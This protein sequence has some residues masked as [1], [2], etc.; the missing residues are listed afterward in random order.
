REDLSGASPGELFDA[1]A[2][3]RTA[4]TGVVLPKGS[5]RVR[6]GLRIAGTSADGG[7]SPAGAPPL[8]SVLLEDRYGIGYRVGAGT[9]PADGRVHTRS[10]PVSASGG[11][12]VTGFEVDGQ[13]PGSP[14]ERLVSVTGLRTITADGVERP[15][16]AADGVRWH[17]AATVTEAGETRPGGKTGTVTGSGPA[18]AFRY[19]T[20]ADT[21]DGGFWAGEP[22]GTLRITADRAAAPALKAVVTD[23]YLK[24]A[25]AEL[26]QEVDLTLAGNTVRV[27][28]VKSVRQLPTTGPGAA[29]G[30]AEGAATD[31]SVKPGGAVLLDLRA[32]SEV[33]AHRPGA[34]LA[35]TEWWLS[36]APGGG[37]E[38]AAELRALPDTDPAQVRV[39]DEV[40]RD[41]AD[42]PLGAGPQ[43]AL[44]AAAV[45]AAA[46][47][48]VGFAVGLVGSQRERA[49][50]FAVL[51]ALGAPRRRLARMMAAEQGVLI[52]LALLIGLALGA[53]LTRAV[54]PLV[55]LT[56]QAARPVPDVLVLLPAGQVAVLLVSV[57][58]LP[59]L[60][61]AA[62]TLR[63][64]DPA[65]SLRHQGDN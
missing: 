4:R 8:V 39:R 58:A 27:T 37:A 54:V 41:L 16:P 36:T 45:V 6:F 20:G 38:V 5:T 25:G 42:D 43:S 23:A 52:T 28:L 15:V 35:P 11:L 47:A 57:A 40:A 59:L 53:V 46:L 56:G 26:G 32:V 30:A 24:Y 13:V 63:R 19:G 22:V 48:A 2:P 17:A 62:I 61:V 9:V 1:I 44:L 12:A 55:V 18:P 21:E 51:R 49:A 10:F 33:L 65:V 7:K 60:F 64:A 14:Q 29:T 31:A 34:T 3:P 50:E